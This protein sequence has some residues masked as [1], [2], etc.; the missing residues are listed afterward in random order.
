MFYKK[1]SIKPIILTCYSETEIKMT[2]HFVDPTEIN[3]SRISE[4]PKWPNN[5]SR[6]SSGGSSLRSEKKT[7]RVY[8]VVSPYQFLTKS[9]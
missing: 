6:N 2:C 5:L 7:L 9:D 3:A 8:L 4:N 1:K